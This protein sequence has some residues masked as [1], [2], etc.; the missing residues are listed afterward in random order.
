M[1]N[2]L[3]E[4]RTAA[5]WAAAGQVIEINEKLGDFERLAA[6]VEADLAV[7]EAGNMPADWRGERVRG[8]LRFSFV[9][10]QHDLPALACRVAVT[11]DAVCQRCLDA[12]R[13]LVETEDNLLLLDAE[14]AVD[15]Y[16]E[17][18]VWELQEATLCPA[19][20][21]EELLVMALPFS[22]MHTEAAAC[23]A[24][25]PASEAARDVTMPFAA[26]REQMAEDK[27]G[28]A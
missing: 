12:F 10:A 23:R 17:Y 2:P 16:D 15:G 24:L 11:V 20:I 18:E 14:Q 21:V 22:A 9:G 3:R 5:E 7:L 6:I 4:R 27:E 19:D 1:G 26:L 28:S 25:A 8:E 13:M